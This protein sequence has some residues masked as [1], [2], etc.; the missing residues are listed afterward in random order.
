MNCTAVVMN[1]NGCTIKGV[2]TRGM[3]IPRKRKD[4]RQEV[5]RDVNPDLILIQESDILPRNFLTQNFGYRDYQVIGK[6]D[7]AVI[8]DTT[9][10]ILL[11]D[12]STRIR[13]I[14]EFKCF[15][16]EISSSKILPKMCAVI[17][18]GKYPNAQP[19]LCVSW[20]A[21]YKKNILVKR[22][23]YDDLCLLIGTYAYQKQIPVIFGGDF[24]LDLSEIIPTIPLPLM[25]LPQQTLTV[26]DYM[27]LDH[28]PN[29]LDYILTSQTITNVSCK[30]VDVYD[31]IEDLFPDLQLLY[32]KV[33]LDHDPLAVN[34]TIPKKISTSIQNN[35]LLAD[36][37][38][39]RKSKRTN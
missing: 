28:R 33:V 19:F 9:T 14:Y 31:T 7:A 38:K 25:I 5:I 13:Q 29:K 23:I 3:E 18:I 30:P 10:F 17:L 8:F 36:S 16:G 26:N 34:I 6:K 4:V 2:R 35:V 39:K 37:K 22:K 15:T 12:P 11:Q 32:Y 21:P 27:K 1:A 24:N 20:H